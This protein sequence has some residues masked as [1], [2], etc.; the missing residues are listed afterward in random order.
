MV[1]GFLFF[2]ALSFFEL[3]ELRLPSGLAVDDLRRELEAV[4]HSLMVDLSLVEQ[5]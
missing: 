4:A 5:D 1:S 2:L 3:W